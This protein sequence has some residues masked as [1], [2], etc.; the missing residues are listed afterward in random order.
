MTRNPAVLVGAAVALVAIGFAAGVGVGGRRAVEEGRTRSDVPSEPPA[1]P[2]SAASTPVSSMRT[3]TPDIPR[4]PDKLRERIVELETELRIVREEA[5]KG[6]A[7]GPGAGPEVARQAY[8]EMLAMESGNFNDPER[9]RSLIL[10]LSR[11]D[12][13]LAREF[14]D[15]YRKAQ[16]A[17]AGENEKFTAIRLALMS[18]GPDA[19]TFVQQLLTDPSVDAQ[20]RSRLL[21]ELSPSGGGF[22]SIRRLP[23]SEP[24]SATAMTLVRSTSAEERRGGAGLLG[25]VPTPA[26]RVELMRLLEDPDASV[27]HVAVRSLGMVGDQT[28]RKLLEPYAAQTADPWLQKL[29]VSAIQE[30]DQATR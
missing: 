4:D 16:G 11:I 17:G 12:S 30:L 6:S 23:V 7:A 5:G 14:I 9:L 26:S 2:R 22:F 15:R 18:G 19:S 1:P 21:G 25:G 13:R 28:T 24:L 8:D 29:A 3:E 27:K 20:L 10:S